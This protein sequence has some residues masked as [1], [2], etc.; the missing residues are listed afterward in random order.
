MMR[1]LLLAFL[2]LLSATAS[3]LE[4][5]AEY[6][7]PAAAEVLFQKGRDAMGAEDFDTA[8]QMF[9]ESFTLDP[10][11]GTVMN[12]AVCEEKRGHLARSWERWSQ[13][14]GLLDENDDRVSYALMQMESVEARLAY[15]TIVAEQGAPSDLTV[16]R[17]DIALGGAGLGHELPVD[18]GP[19]VVIVESR[20]YQPRRYEISLEVGERKELVVTVGNAVHDEGG[21]GSANTRKTAGIVA[22]GVGALG[23]GV[24]VTTAV[25][26]PGQHEK[27]EDACPAKSCNE[28]GLRALSGAKTLLALNT[29]GFIAAGVGAVTGVTLLLTLPKKEKDAPRAGSARSV[30]VGLFG[31]GIQVNGN[32]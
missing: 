15:L 24:A 25:L 20:G 21:A 29:A 14:L 11:V 13:A 8:C 31:S 30:S 7:D 5:R 18:P 32:F 27:V 10:A 28:E 9:E 19:H 23:L 16:R 2:I 26:L 22:L 1:R 12:L 3:P 17:D 4:A 6:R